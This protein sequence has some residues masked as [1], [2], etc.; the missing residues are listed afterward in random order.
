MVLYGNLRGYSLKKIIYIIISAFIL[1]AVCT[2]PLP[3]NIDK[4]LS[5]IQWRD[6]EL[7]YSENV[8][9]K[10][11]GIYKIYLFRSNKFQGH[12]T[13]SNIER[14]QIKYSQMF[15][16]HLYKS[17]SN[18]GFLGYAVKGP[19]GDISVG[20]ISVKGLFDK[21]LIKLKDMNEAYISA[22]AKDR[23]EA[24]EVAVEVNDI[25]NSDLS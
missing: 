15:D 22:P 1:L 6:G 17:R 3:V 9:M 23:H 8:N 20:W 24:L 4:T 14:S 11:K 12:I 21:I 16:L 5:G 10:I 2:L 13:F 7:G 18:S 19:Q 25:E